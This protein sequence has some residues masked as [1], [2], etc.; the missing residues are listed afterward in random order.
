MKPEVEVVAKQPGWLVRV[1]FFT[2]RHWYYEKSHAFEQMFACE[3]R[4][5]RFAEEAKKSNLIKVRKMVEAGW[6]KRVFG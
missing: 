3:V 6:I 1:E 2:N 4:A 5:R